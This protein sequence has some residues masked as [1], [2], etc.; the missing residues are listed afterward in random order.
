M[1]IKT[2]SGFDLRNSLS[3]GLV[4]LNTTSFSAVASQAVN[5]VF[6][7]T[8]NNYKILIN[9]TASTADGSLLLRLRNG[10]T[11]KA[12]NYIYAMYGRQST[13]GGVVSAS[14]TS[15]GLYLQDI[16]STATYFGMSMDLLNPFNTTKTIAL[17]QQL[18]K[19]TDGN[20]YHT[21]ISTYQTEDY[22]ADGVNLIVGAGA[23][24]GTI[25]VYGYNK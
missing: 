13:S 17:Q 9:I 22:S 25:S 6:S 18:I 5:T 3:S 20:D 21:N 19:A 10:T 7:A 23:I 24:T 11:D 15:T 12:T 2:A 1:A 8:Y 14:S 4:L 16:D